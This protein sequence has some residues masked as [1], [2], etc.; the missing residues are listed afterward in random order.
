MGRVAERIVGVGV[1]HR[2]ADD[3]RTKL[4]FTEYLTIGASFSLRV[5]PEAVTAKRCRFRRP[6]GRSSGSTR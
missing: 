5:Q 6:L 1:R 2:P 3:R 4:Y